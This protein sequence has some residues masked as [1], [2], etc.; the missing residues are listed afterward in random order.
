MKTSTQLGNGVQLTFSAPPAPLNRFATVNGVLTALA[1]QDGMTVTFA[2]P[3]AN[4]AVVAV[5]YGNDIV[6]P[7][8]AY[9]VTFNSLPVMPPPIGA[10]LT[11]FLNVSAVA[12]T[13]PSLSVRVQVLDVVS[14][15][16]MDV[17][18]AVFP[19]MTA[20]GVATLTIFPG[21]TVTA[22]ASVNQ[23]VRNQYRVVSTITGTTPSFTFSIGSQA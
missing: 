1:S 17:P 21:A 7:P 23:S 4:L 13:T 11:L 8:A 9:T 3:P 2:A 20:A 6:V 10:A 16:W 12:G 19:T 18:N 15:V 14:G 22:N 5:S